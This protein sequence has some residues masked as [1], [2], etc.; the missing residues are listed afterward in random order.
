MSGPQS[1]WT[2]L[3]KGYSLSFPTRTIQWVMSSWTKTE[4]LK[5]AR[6]NARCTSCLPSLSYP[7]PTGSVPHDGPATHARSLHTL[8]FELTY[9]LQRSQ[10]H[11]GWHGSRGTTVGY[12]WERRA[13]PRGVPRLV[14]GCYMGAKAVW[15]LSS[16]SLLSPCCPLARTH[17]FTIKNRPK[18]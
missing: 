14:T 4:A 9:I 10:C 13:M 7:Y 2:T 18:K 12:L 3:I 16:A 15:S 17:P 8:W 1:I 5:R 11:T 6:P